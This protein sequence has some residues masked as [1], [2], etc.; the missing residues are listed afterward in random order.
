[1][2]Y[3]H[4]VHLIVACIVF[5]YITP[6]CQGFICYF[7]TWRCKH[8]ILVMQWGLV[9]VATCHDCIGHNNISLGF[10]FSFVMSYV[11]LLFYN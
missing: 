3:N 7:F 6:K 9:V 2:T 1:M 4:N 10:T 5:C 11:N 8:S